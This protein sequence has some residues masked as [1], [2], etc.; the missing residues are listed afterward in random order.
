MFSY[1]RLKLFKNSIGTCVKVILYYGCY[2][3]GKREDMNE[4][5][6]IVR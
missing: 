3:I 6:E 5:S 2:I 4:T 1:L